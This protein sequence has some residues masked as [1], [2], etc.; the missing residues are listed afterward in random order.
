MNPSFIEIQKFNKWW[1]YIIAGLPVII[2]GTISVL[3]GL[4][5]LKPE[6][7]QSGANGC[8]TL[9]GIVAFTL[10]SFIWFISLKLKTIIDQ[11]GIHVHF[12]GF[13]FCNKKI[14]WDEIETI[15]FI[16]YSPL[17]DYGGWGVRR[18][19]SGNDWCYNVSGEYGIKLIRTNGKP[20]LIGTQ[21]KE[22]AEKIINHYLN[23]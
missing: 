15:S 23:K 17:S 1:H 8:I 10:I 21:Q 20:F 16:K 4:N 5:I 18:S 7:E 12:Y 9:S 19:M 13:P 14:S 22:E 6:D 11:Q 2:I 3:A